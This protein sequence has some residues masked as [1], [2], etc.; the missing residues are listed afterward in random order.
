MILNSLNNQF[1]IRF[2]KSFFYPEI[3]AKWTPVVKR[4][5]LPYENLEDFINASVQSLAFPSIESI[6]SATV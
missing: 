2:P 1:V 6:N 4:L 5:K 3:H